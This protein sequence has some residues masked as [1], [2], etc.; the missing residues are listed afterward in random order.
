MAGN[1]WFIWCNQSLSTFYFLISIHFLQSITCWM[2]FT[3]TCIWFF[4]LLSIVSG[5]KVIRPLRVYLVLLVADCHETFLLLAE[6]IYY[7]PGPGAIIVSFTDFAL[8]I[9]SITNCR[10]VTPFTS[11]L[12][13]TLLYI[14]FILKVRWTGGSSSG[15][16]RWSRSICSSS[17][18]RGWR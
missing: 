13:A 7:I 5:R 14:A 10:A 6:F 9:A 4:P 15:G 11:I 12:K 8:L 18:V 1:T 2:R 16:G 3:F 17:R